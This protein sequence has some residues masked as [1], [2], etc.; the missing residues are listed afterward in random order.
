VVVANEDVVWQEHYVKFFL[1][2][3][4]DPLATYTP[5]KALAIKSDYGTDMMQLVRWDKLNTE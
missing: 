5:N 3:Q 4:H 2:H 1:E